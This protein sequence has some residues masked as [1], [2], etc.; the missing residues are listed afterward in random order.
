MCL[1]IHFWKKKKT[2]IYFSRVY[3]RVKHPCGPLGRVPSCGPAGIWGWAPCAVETVLCAVGFSN[4]PGPSLLGASGT[5]PPVVTTELCSD[6]AKSSPGDRNPPGCEVLIQDS[7][8]HNASCGTY[9]SGK[10][11]HFY[12]KFN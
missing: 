4:V 8:S 2:N 3:C 12:I 7:I 10:C 6:V 1:C 9:L 11:M 5:P